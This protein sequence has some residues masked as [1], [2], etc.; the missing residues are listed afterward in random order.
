MYQRFDT[1]PFNSDKSAGSPPID[2]EPPSYASDSDAQNQADQEAH[3][4]PLLR[5]N[6]H[7][8]FGMF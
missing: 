3:E 7:I 1:V 2:G 5:R 8:A 6:P 4:L